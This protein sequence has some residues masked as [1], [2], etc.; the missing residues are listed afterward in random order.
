MGNFP[1]WRLVI[2]TPVMTALD[3]QGVDWVEV[4]L[5]DGGPIRILPGHAPLLAETRAGEI[6]YVDGAGER[7]FRVRAG[8]LSISP[9]QVQ[10]F[11]STLPNA[12]PKEPA[13]ASQ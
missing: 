10:I 8:V 7:A 3:V 12:R 9:G 5:A 1:P 6:R 4:Q 13:S 2:R 11:T